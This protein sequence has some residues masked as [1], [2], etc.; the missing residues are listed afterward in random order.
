MSAILFLMQYFY[1]VNVVWVVNASISLIHFGA[2]IAWVKYVVPRVII[3]SENLS[4]LWYHKDMSM[5]G[6]V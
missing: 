2:T 3:S 6:R 5:S 4:R 1:D